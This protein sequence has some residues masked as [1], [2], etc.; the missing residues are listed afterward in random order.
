M[1]FSPYQIS[2]MVLIKM[3]ETAEAY[4]GKEVVHAV[5]S[6][7]TYFNAMQRQATMDA[8]LLAGLNVLR[9][10]NG[11]SAAAISY[12]LGKGVD[13]NV[14]INVLIY[15]LGGGTCDVSLVAMYNDVLEVLATACDTH[16]G[17]KDFDN[18]L[19]RK[20]ETQA[21]SHRRLRWPGAG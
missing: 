4:L 3:K 21:C 18:R 13:R 17:G 5:I 2:S 11:T 14:L 9:L 19:V 6:V 10:I 15:D 7:P 8:G 16:L 1:T 20:M 12:V